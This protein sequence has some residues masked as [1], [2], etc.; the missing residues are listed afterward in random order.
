MS[1]KLKWFLFGFA[2][3]M[4]LFIAG[5]FV[6]S[7]LLDAANVSKSKRDLAQASGLDEVVRT[8]H[9]AHGRYPISKSEV[10]EAQD[11]P[12]PERDFDY[13]VENGH[14]MLVYP[15]LTGTSRDE[16]Y[17]FQDGHLAAFPSRMNDEIAR[18]SVQ[19]GGAAGRRPI[20]E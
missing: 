11:R 14:Y 6:M 19:R 13:F 4:T 8:F 20:F 5:A 1:Q 15:S 17:V 16:P 12:S 18:M 2:C 9:D 3:A 10:I 7:N